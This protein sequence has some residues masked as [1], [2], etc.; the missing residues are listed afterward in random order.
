MS[1]DK[2]KQSQAASTKNDKPAKV[3]G[4]VPDFKPKPKNKATPPPTPLIYFFES[5]PLAYNL[6]AGSD[7]KGAPPSSRQIAFTSAEKAIASYSES[8]RTFLFKCA[9]KLQHAKS[10]KEINQAEETFLG[11]VCTA[12]PV[13]MRLRFWKFVAL[14]TIKADVPGVRF[15]V[16]DDLGLT[17]TQ[18]AEFVKRVHLEV[19]K[20]A[21]GIIA[22]DA[23]MA[24]MF[25]RLTSNPQDTTS[26]L[27]SE[28]YISGVVPKDLI[29]E[30]KEYLYQSLTAWAR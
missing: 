1:K 27:Y 9:Q 5:E 2:T 22:K 18:R 6:Y 19:K 28:F 12:G 20:E 23:S 25:A 3:K 11:A 26:E 15:N 29:P 30:G 14:I 7:D 17:G 8:G 4:P 16:E 21:E 24:D 10:F 13:P